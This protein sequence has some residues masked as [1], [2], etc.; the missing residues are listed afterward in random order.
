M[1]L[2]WTKNMAWVWRLR[3]ATWLL[4]KPVKLLPGQAISMYYRT[5]WLCYPAIAN[6][7]NLFDEMRAELVE[8]TRLAVLQTDTEEDVLEPIDKRKK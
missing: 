2:P 3:I 1:I 7:T 8:I 6:P 5:P 4:G